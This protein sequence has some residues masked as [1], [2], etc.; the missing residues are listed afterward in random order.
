MS[1]I[2]VGIIGI[3]VLIVLLLIGIPV[4]ITMMIVGFVG[5]AYLSGFN[6]AIG[7][8]GT[9]FYR[10]AASYTLTVVPLFC[11]MGQLCY[12]SD[13]S[14]D[15][16]QACNRLLGRLPGGLGVAT[17][18]A[19]GLFA[20]ICGSSTATAATF[21]TVAVPEMK[22]NH[23]DI[24][25]ATSTVVAGGTLGI[26]IP[27][28]VGF[29]MYGLIAEQ[30]IGQ[31]FAA[32]VIPGIMLCV[33]YMV[34][35]IVLCVINPA[36]GPRSKKYTFAE[37]MKGLVGILP[38]L[39]L[40]VVVIGGIFAGFFT[41]NEGS[42]IGAIG[43]FIVLVIR[44]GLDIKALKRA[45]VDTLHS[46]AMIFVIMMGANV[47]GYFLAITTI[48][49]TLVTVIGGMNVNRYVILAII[50]FA[51]IVMGC[52]MDSL[53]MIVLTVP[54]FIP[55]VLALGF[56]PIWYGVIMVLC[57]EMG[58]ITPPVGMNLYVVKGILK[59]E[60]TMGDL[61]KGIWPYLFAIL[62]LI[63]ILVIFPNIA[64]FLPNLLYS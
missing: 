2:T 43:A 38:M 33:F 51:Y 63:I 23:Y 7:V 11:L 53:S 17:I 3:V 12:E 16:Y 46:T 40:F 49:A 14:R 34:V 41:A 13:M 1:P 55:V 28:S 30:S 47:F 39:V 20:A 54:I 45:A 35:V 18:G 50:I 27:P 8:V 37:K 26:L 25:V 44:K 31:L 57:Q 64:T 60:V 9:T 22:R 24:K 4:G 21:C 19:C 56:D 62:A 5:F 29:I 48:P 6:S 42:A 59:D 61:I 32:G 58:Q 10:T 36:N 52:I 15:M